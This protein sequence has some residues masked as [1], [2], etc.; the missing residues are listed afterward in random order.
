MSIVTSWVVPILGTSLGITRHFIAT[1]EV[2]AVRS[3]QHL[4]VSM[5]S[6]PLEA[7][8]TACSKHYSRCPQYM[9]WHGRWGFS[10]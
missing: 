2:L 7:L 1:G 9:W 8:H 4:G 3:G 10:V 6:A 5:L